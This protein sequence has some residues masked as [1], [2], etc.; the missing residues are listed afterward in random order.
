MSVL[1]PS[2]PLWNFRS[3]K[4]YLYNVA[5]TLEAA[6]ERDR[7]RLTSRVLHADVNVARRSAAELPRRPFDDERP[8]PPIRRDHC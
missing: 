6:G 1:Q 4:K 3:Q 5:S 2:N 7:Y 8:E